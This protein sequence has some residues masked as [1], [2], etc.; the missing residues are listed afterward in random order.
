MIKKIIKIKGVGR[1]KAFDSRNDDYAFDKTTIIFGYNTYGK[2]TLTSIFRSLKDGNKNYIYGRKTLGFNDNQEIEILDENH[3]SYSLNSNWKNENIEI[4][5]NDFISKNVFYGDYIDKEQQS[6]LYGILVGDEVY[7]L[8]QEID[9]AKEDQG[10]LE[11]EKA[12]AENGFSKRDLGTVTEFFSINENGGSETRIQELKEQILQQENLEHLKAIIS[13]TPL[14]SNF[15]NFKAEF[16]KTLDL[17]FEETVN[18]H[19]KNNW[20]DACASKDF[21]S[22]G[23]ELLKEGGGCVFC[24][25]DLS[26]VTT[27]IGDLQKVFSNEYKNLKRSIKEIGDRF[28]SIDLE[29]SFSDFEKYGLNVRNNLD[30]ENLQSAKTNIDA[31]VRKKQEDLNLKIDFDFDPDF[32]TFLEELKKIYVALSSVENQSSDNSAKLAGL[33][34]E[35]RNQELMKY[36][37]SEDGVSI[38]KAYAKSKD[39]LEKKKSEIK[40]LNEDLAKKV[41]EVFSRYE[42]QINFFL[43]HLHANFSLRNFSQKSHMG[44]INTHFCEYRFVIDNLH[45]VPISNKKRKDDPEPEDKPHFKNTL[46]DSDKRLLAFAFYFAK[47]TNDADLKN[48]IIV[49][50]DPF[51]SFDENRKDETITLLNNLKNENKDVPAQKI[52]LTHDRGFLCRLFEKTTKDARRIIKIHYSQVSGSALDKCDVENEFLKDRYFRDIEYIKNSIESANNIDEALAKSRGCLEHVLK[53]KYY[54]LLKPD[55][56]KRKSI[57]EYLKEIGEVCGIKDEILNDNWHEDMHDGH[58]IMQLEAPSKIAKLSRLLELI[59]K[60]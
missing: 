39:D 29:R 35:L 31:K 19:I 49:L 53:R 13:K 23:L 2:S 25:Q 40:R 57:G 20:K 43:K 46:S 48:K 38:F 11:K 58:Q 3:K 56:I 60:V 41:D 14:K 51:S 55:T 12:I 16:L 45:E 54:F 30:F 37:F 34:N 36:R 5:D 50:D 10:K 33:K 18:R 1:F 27:F 22:N 8:K 47:L 15:N 42:E 21:L 7:K 59:Q 32:V 17:T 6:S 28:I 4:F 52:I 44:S 26:N 9:K 24:G